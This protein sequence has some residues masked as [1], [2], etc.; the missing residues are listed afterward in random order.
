MISVF[1]DTSYLLALE[2]SNDQNHAAAGRHW[3][4]VTMALPRL[5]TTSYVFDEIVTFFNCRGY[6]A[7]SAICRFVAVLYPSYAG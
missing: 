7:K 5:M 4:Q 3:G 6:H 1:I 2:L